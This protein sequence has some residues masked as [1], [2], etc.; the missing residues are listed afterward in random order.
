MAWTKTEHGALYYAD[1]QSTWLGSKKAVVNSDYATDWVNWNNN[2]YHIFVNQFTGYAPKVVFTEIG[3][4]D[5]GTHV[6]SYTDYKT[7]GVTE[8]LAATVFGNLMSAVDGLAFSNNCTII[9]FRLCD[10]EGV[11]AAEQATQGYADIYVHGE[12]NLG[13]IEEDGTIKAIMKEYYYVIN[14]T[15]DTTALQTEVNKYYD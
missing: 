13:L 12:G 7:I 1:I 11:Y 8:S 9:A 14:G 2:L 5:Y 6:S 3:M 15:R 4:I 10:L